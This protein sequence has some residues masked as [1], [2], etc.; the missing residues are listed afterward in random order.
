MGITIAKEIGIEKIRNACPLFD[1]W[2][3]IFE[4]IQRG[5]Q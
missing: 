4:E 5:C 3:T 1:A 2:L